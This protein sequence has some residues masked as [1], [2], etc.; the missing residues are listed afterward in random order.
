MKMQSTLPPTAAPV[1]IQGFVNGCAAL[2]A[3][4]SS[5][6]RL[7][8]EIR[9]TFGVEHVFLMSSGKAALALILSGLRRLSP[10]RKVVM[11]AYTCYSVPS[12]AVK[13]G[14][15][16]ALCD[17]DPTTLDLDKTQLERTF[18]EHTLCVL[19][20]HLFGLPA[21]VEG[22]QALCRPRGITV[23]E[24]AAQALG[25]VCGG[26]WLGTGGDVGFFSL[27]RGKNISSGGG[28]VIVTRSSIVAGAIQEEYD[29]LPTESRW[30]A[31]KNLGEL[32]ATE[33]FIR[34]H[35]YWLPAGLPF[36]GLGETRFYRDFPVERMANA[37]AGTL[38]G[39]RHRLE[40]TN[41]LRREQ[42]QAYV[43]ELA[44]LASEVH[45]ITAAEASYLRLPL[46]LRDRKVKQ[47]LCARA[48][49]LGLG[50]SGGYP[51]T[52]QQIPELQ[53]RLAAREYPGAME[54]VERLVTLPTHRFVRQAD[55]M[56]MCR[57]IQDVS[58]QGGLK[59]NGE[60]EVSHSSSA[61][62]AASRT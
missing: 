20:T 43:Q 57:L 60:S 44:A 23:V 48:A 31:M 47:T 46:L 15:D 45:A 16:V 5:R 56:R 30:T 6:D 33:A 24:D 28:G 32:L 55:R 34:P 11:P 51:G 61:V 59:V 35:L 54:V 3:T 10:K 27:G 18:D 12:A 36:L 26:R 62:R 9:D 8:R 49:A 13:A 52:I 4:R 39:W 42:A 41:G 19:P 25:G 29:K 38:R 17:V 1:P 22:V 53:D 21:D 2:L 7:E 14:L 58:A 50:I 37:R 40:A